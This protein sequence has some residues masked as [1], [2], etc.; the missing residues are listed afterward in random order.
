[1]STLEE[2]PLFPVHTVLFPGASLRLHVF[3]DRY[4]LLIKRCLDT[5]EP[6]GVVLIRNGAEVGNPAEPF[7]VG[8]KVQIESVFEY[9]DGRFDIQIRGEDRFRVRRLDESQP[10]L[11]GYAEPVDDEPAA[12]SVD[13]E[14]LMERAREAFRTLIRQIYA[15]TEIEVTVSFPPDALGLS[16]A[17]ANYLPIDNR[18]K[19]R[20]LETTD[21]YERL[22]E[23]VDLVETQL[24]NWE[25]PYQRM[26][27]GMMGD[28]V[29]PN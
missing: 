16:F 8:T 4:R 2:V 17:L 25:G 28:W 23:L 3:E 22:S 6:F 20:L 14:P 7:M 19:Q 12:T 18:H 15:Q 10:Y 27:A 11:V 26:N 5:Q 29:T 24:E 1:M 21:T 13:Y 9:E